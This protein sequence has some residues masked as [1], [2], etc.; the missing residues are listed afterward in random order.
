MHCGIETIILDKAPQANPHSGPA[1]TAF[2]QSSD[3][4]GLLRLNLLDLLPIRLVGLSDG[5]DHTFI[6]LPI[7]I[8]S[9]VINTVNPSLNIS[10]SHSS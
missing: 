1:P 5:F 3:S 9:R 2:R 10:I 6:D 7:F 4:L 8:D